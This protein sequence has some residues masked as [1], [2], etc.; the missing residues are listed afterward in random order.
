MAHKTAVDRSKGKD[1]KVIGASDDPAFSSAF[2]VVYPSIPIPQQG[3]F[4][5]DGTQDIEYEFH[6]SSLEGIPLFG[7]REREELELLFESSIPTFRRLIMDAP[8]E[9]VNQDHIDCE[10]AQYVLAHDGI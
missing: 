9:L 4:R 5:A 7:D 3:A 6:Y 10:R 2:S 8:L 1:K